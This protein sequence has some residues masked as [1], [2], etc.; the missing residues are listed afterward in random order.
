M[1]AG[2]D[3]GLRQRPPSA[4]RQAATEGGAMDGEERG[5][6]M[7]TTIKLDRERIRELF[8]LRRR[9]GGLFAA[10]TGDPYPALHRLRETGPVHPG[11]VHE[12][13]GFDGPA[14]FHGLPEP[15]R[16]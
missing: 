16:E 15:D 13:I 3:H 1:P 11:I 6:D 8:D 12:L 5:V 10:Y 7:G 14:G 9:G 2:R 4:G